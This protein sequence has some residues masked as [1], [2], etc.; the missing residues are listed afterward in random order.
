[1]RLFVSMIAL[2]LGLNALNYGQEQLPITNG[3]ALFSAVK[4]ETTFLKEHNDYFITP[5]FS[6]AILQYQGQEILIKG[7]Y[8]PLELRERN[9]LILSKF[10]YAACFFCGGAG[11]E[12]VAEVVFEGKMP[13]LNADQVIQVYAVL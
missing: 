5:T 6:K 12:S 11:P 10:P 9:T 3:W 4:F 7:H 2:L 1:M 13:K 8:L